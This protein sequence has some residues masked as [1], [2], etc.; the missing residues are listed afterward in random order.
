[1]KTKTIIIPVATYVGDE[2]GRIANLLGI[3]VEA[4]FAYFFYRKG[5]SHLNAHE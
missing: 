4:L 5:G 2:I 1:M 3:S